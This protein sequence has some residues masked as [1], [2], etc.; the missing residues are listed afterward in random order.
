MKFKD[1]KVKDFKCFTHLTVR[2]VPDTARLIILT[3]PNG[4]GKSSF[5]DALY[6]WKQ[7]QSFQIATD[8]DYYFK[9]G[10]QNDPRKTKLDVQIEF[11]DDIP[12]DQG[13][14]K[15]II[16]V[17][18]AYRNEPE[19]QSRKI[20][21]SRSPI[22]ELRVIRMID[23]DAAVS[24]NYQR[25]AGEIFKGVFE[26]ADG[27]MTLDEFRQRTI[28]EIREP[29]KRLFPD[30]ELNSL[31][32][33]L[34]DGTFYFTKGTSQRFAFMNLSAGEKAA[35]DLI[36]DLVVS[37]SE[38]DNTVFCIDEPDSHMN[39]KLQSELLSVLYNLIPKNCQ[40]MLATHSVGMIRQAR[41]IEAEKPGSVIFLDFGNRNFDE[42]Q[43]IEP[44][45]PD[46][47]FW[48]STYHIAFDDLASLVAPS[49]VVICEG[50]PKNRNTAQNYSHDA[51]CYEQIFKNEF[52][53]TQF[54]PGGSNCDVAEDRRGISY[55]LG[56]LVEG[57]QVVR[58][59]D[60]DDR[61]PE[62]IAELAEK[63]IRVLSRRNLESYLFDD[64]VLQALAVSEDKGDKLDD[65]LAEKQRIRSAN[66]DAPA[67]DIKLSSGQIYLACKDILNLI[68][69]GNDAKTFMRDT[70]SVLIKPG[71]N[72]YEEL[73]HDVF[74]LQE[75]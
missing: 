19:F 73:K 72:V 62:E 51:R 20:E 24:K 70:L 60:R 46:R 42:P 39:A 44:V 27:S 1:A 49:R 12:Q 29:L 74:G 33:P 75:Y 37:R 7:Q 31:T 26:Q 16:H 61:S 30:L 45:R 9:A 59:I 56:L 34:R 47:K 2:G 67:D 52:P 11:H 55:A 14:I 68:G 64:E 35:F 66:T 63:G 5:F 71:M 6:V 36:L 43:I 22:D 3:G 32:D 48:E 15:K 58:L 57:I 8:R 10:T 40:L 69:C 53:E 38:F 13:Q 18:S 41:D 28:K 21:N 65:L 23:N 4:C 25:M 17:R 50:E 54:V